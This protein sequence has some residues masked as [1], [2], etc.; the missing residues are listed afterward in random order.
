MT[1]WIPDLVARGGYAGL[2]FLMFLET[3]FPPVPSEVIMP[4]AGVEAARGRLS[5]LGAVIAGASGAMGGNICWYLLARRLG[6]TAFHAF[7]QRHG[8][9]LT[10]DWA[11]VERG[12]AAFRRRGSLYVCV[13]RM[14]PFVRT[15]ISIPA[16]LL[17]MRMTPFL[18]WSAIGTFGWTAILTCAG[19]LLGARYAEVEQVLSPVAAVVMAAAALAYLVR[20][21][22]WRPR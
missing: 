17:D 4:F 3:L 19:Y 20:L 7:V 12:Q 15:M 5:L 21:V 14:V 8:R 1:D 11:D 6:H 10:L 22:L 9:L 13:G 18:V 16:G 2:A